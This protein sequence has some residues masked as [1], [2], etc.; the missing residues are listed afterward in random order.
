MEK[1]LLIGGGN[2]AEIYAQDHNTVV[3]LFYSHC[4]REIVLKEV[5]INQELAKHPWAIPKYGSMLGELHAAM[6]QISITGLGS[7]K[8]TLNWN[9]EQRKL[10]TGDKKA[11]VLAYLQHLPDGKAL[12]HGDF[13]PDNVL[14]SQKGPVIIDWITATTGHPYVD[15][16][17]TSLLILHAEPPDDI[18]FK[19][20]LRAAGKLFYRSYLQ[21]YIRLTNAPREEI[22][23]WMVPLAAARLIE[24]VPAEEKQRLLHLID[25]LLITK[26]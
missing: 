23:A 11:Q 19:E 4:S 8:S 3:K 17:R 10:L 21:T 7:L 9:I 22:A 13:H 12:C 26:N 2:T 1:S 16:A 14:L 15:V 24:G 20:L 18:P 25:R 5:K 6:H